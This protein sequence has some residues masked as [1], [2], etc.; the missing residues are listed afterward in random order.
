MIAYQFNLAG[1]YV[2]ET[3][4]DESPMEPGV[5]LVPAHCTLIAPPADV[6]DGRWPRFNGTSWSLVILLRFAG[7]YQRDDTGE[8]TAVEIVA[9][10]RYETID[11]GDAK[12]GENTEHKFTMACTYYKL[13]VDGQEVIEIDLLNFIEKV[14]GQ[15]ILAAQRKAI[16][17]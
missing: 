7:A 1:L 13:T 4:A 3:E 6:P 8:V 10:G 15:D 9:R 2:G 5:Y 17:L 14:D 16:G 12:P 11:P